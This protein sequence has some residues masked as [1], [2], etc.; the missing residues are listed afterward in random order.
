MNRLEKWSVV[1]TATVV[2]S[3]NWLVALLRVLVNFYNAFCTAFSNESTAA[4]QT[5]QPWINVETTLIVNVH[6][7]CFNV[8]IWLNMRVEPTSIYWRCFSV[9]KTTI[10]QR[11]KNYVDSTSINQHCLKVEIWLKIKVE[12]TYVYRRCFNVDKTV[13]KELRWFNVDDSM[14]FQRW[15]SIENQSWVK[16]CSSAL[17]RRGENSIETT[18][19]IFVVLMLTTK[20]RNNKTKFSSK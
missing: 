9:R 19:S 17:L 11:R 15:Y 18:L 5:H 13:L 7:C 14:L 10:K 8:D 3:N 12:S 2:N 16:V 4:Q 20:C 6:Q 1:P